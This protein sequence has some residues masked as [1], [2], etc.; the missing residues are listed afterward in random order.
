MSAVEYARL[1]GAG[2]FKIT[3]PPQ[4]AMY[5]FG[6]AVCV[7]AIAWID[8]HILTPVFEKT[9]SNAGGRREAPA[10]SVPTK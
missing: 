7:P 6:D 9:A 1:Q 2:D 5:E 3:V 8:R 4:Q 10:I